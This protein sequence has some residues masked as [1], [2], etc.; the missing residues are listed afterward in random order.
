MWRAE[1]SSTVV[2]SQYLSSKIK[3]SRILSQT[4]AVNTRITAQLK[5]LLGISSGLRKG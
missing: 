5:V 3:K 2:E 1:P 4:M